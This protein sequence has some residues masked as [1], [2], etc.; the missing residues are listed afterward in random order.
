MK[1]NPLGDAAFDSVVDFNEARDYMALA[2]ASY[3]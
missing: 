2:D 3:K 1:T